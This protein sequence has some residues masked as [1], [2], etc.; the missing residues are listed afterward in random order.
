[1][2]ITQ[3]NILY[4][5]SR[6]KAKTGPK[7]YNRKYTSKRIPNDKRVLKDKHITNAY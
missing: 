2:S 7:P 1:M 4:K 5:S 3:N 6:F